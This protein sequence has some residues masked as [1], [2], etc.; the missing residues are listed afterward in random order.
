MLTML[1]VNTQNREER[2]Q[3]LLRKAETMRLKAIRKRKVALKHERSRQVENKLAQ[4]VCQA[5]MVNDEMMDD[6]MMK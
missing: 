2:R 6:E 5:V 3:I 4:Y 1:F